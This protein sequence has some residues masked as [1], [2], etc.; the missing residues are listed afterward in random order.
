M[1]TTS[2]LLRDRADRIRDEIGGLLDRSSVRIGR[3][4]IGGAYIVGPVN[5]WVSLDTEGRRAQSKI[6]ADYDRY[7]ATISVLLRGQ[8]AEA[9]GELAAANV[10]IREI[11]DQSASTWI[12]T[13]DEARAKVHDAIE[14]QK[15]LLDRLHDGG[16]GEAAY[17]PDTNALLHH[18]DLD[19]WT[20]DESPKFELVLV[21]TVLVELDELKVNHRNED[22]RAKAEGLIRRIKGYRERGRLSD[23]VVLR[24]GVSTLRTVATEPRMG[25]SL[26]WLDPDNRDDRLLA[27]LV[28]VMRSRPRTPVVIVSKD[29]NLQ[30]KAEAASLPFV[31]PPDP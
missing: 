23:G 14:K 5:D 17:V 18:V 29:V 11:V 2:E 27:S 21:P 10:R 8:P 9:A 15:E 1:Q 26:P 4:D 28:E 24:G 31:E 22:V 25:E 19:D 20:F 6:L 12:D 7:Y 13:V 16:A 3:H 30:N